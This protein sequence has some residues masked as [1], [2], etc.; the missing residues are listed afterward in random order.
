MSSTPVVLVTGASRGLGRALAEHFCR[1]GARVIGCSRSAPE[2]PLEGYE[3]F[4]VDV[5]NERA[6][7][8]MFAEIRKRHGRLDVLVNN[9]A[10]NPAIAPAMLVPSEAIARSFEVN[11]L[12]AMLVCR[13]AIGLMIRGRFGRIVNIGSMAVRL[14]VAGES[15]YTAMKAALTAYTRVLAKEVWRYGITCN[16]V[17]PSALPTGLS[18]Q[19]DPA[20]LAKALERNAIPEIGRFEDVV[21]VVDWLIRK[22]SQAVT[23]QT[24]YLG[25]A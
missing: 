3:H 7:K 18:A 8:G 22:E 6:V 2:S 14:E 1:T 19:V 21:N 11:L 23:G 17:A 15:V 10:I 24:I 9:A 25:G 5:S 12:G 16:V 20:A 13:G 4:A